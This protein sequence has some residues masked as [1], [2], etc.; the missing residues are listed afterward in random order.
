MGFEV[1]DHLLEILLGDGI[2]G[3]GA[4]LE[5]GIEFIPDGKRVR[6]GSCRCR[7]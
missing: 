2:L 7:R 3:Q 4:G 5:S 1:G 6:L